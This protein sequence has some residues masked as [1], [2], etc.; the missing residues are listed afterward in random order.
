LQGDDIAV[1]RAVKDEQAIAR[2]QKNE[3]HQGQ[4]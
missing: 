3:R 2:C 4:I 1:E